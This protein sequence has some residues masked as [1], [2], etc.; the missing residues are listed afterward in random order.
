MYIV[1]IR[2]G[3][4][5]LFASLIHVPDFKQ[6]AS[7]VLKGYTFLENIQNWYLT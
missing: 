3:W 5:T 7:S 4:R 1:T 6:K 2:S